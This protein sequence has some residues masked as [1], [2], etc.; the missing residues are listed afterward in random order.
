[1]IECKWATSYTLPV[2]ATWVSGLYIAN[3]T[4]I[5]SGKQSRTWFVVRNDSSKSDLVF[6]S[7]FTTFQ[8]YNSFGTGANGQSV[9]RSLYTSNS[10]GGIAAQ[11]VSY[12]RP[13]AQETIAPWELNNPMNYEYNMIRWLESQGYDVTYLTNLDVH[14]S[15]A[16]LLN[17]KT[18][19][20]VAHDEYWSLEMRNAVE[21]A[22]DKGV[23]LGFF[24]ANTAYWRIR[25]EPSSSG[26]AN[27]VE[28]CYKY[29]ALGFVDPVAPTDRWRDSDNNRPENAMLGVM[30]I[31]DNDLIL[32][33]LGQDFL[34]INTTDKYYANTGLSNLTHLSQLVGF[35]WDGVVDNTVYGASTNSTPPGLV[36]LSSSQVVASDIAPGLP[37]SY[38][39]VSNAAR[40]TA[41]SGAHVFATGSIQWV[42]GLD[43]FG[44]NPSKVDQ[45]VQQMA[46]NILGDMKA[47]PASPSTGLVIP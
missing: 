27:R 1:L 38:P 5:T 40:Y 8:A 31:G 6:Q 28:V 21:G 37:S 43:S 9:T 17:H 42:W 46:V 29:P 44:V 33:D 10:T 23:N 13:F 45:R 19:L 18:Y 26:V 30:Y 4:A 12:D 14:S 47:R 11:K 34:P 32:A 39:E 7:A 36:V 35:E 22:R 15:P 16:L 20:S 41:A 24:S 25:F 3:F 2:G